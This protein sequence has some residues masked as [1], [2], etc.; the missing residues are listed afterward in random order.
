MKEL[1][2]NQLESWVGGTLE[3]ECFQIGIVTFLTW[4]LSGWVPYT[5]KWQECL[6]N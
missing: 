4:P 5:R 1:K 6:D 2:L 3:Q